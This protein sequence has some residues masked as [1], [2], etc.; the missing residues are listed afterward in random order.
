MRRLVAWGAACPDRKKPEL[1]RQAA[2]AYYEFR[3]PHS[4]YLPR[5][6]AFGMH[7]SLKKQ[8]R[9]KHRIMISMDY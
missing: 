5:K 7:L 1:H 9:S 8:I 6:D 4:D 2:F 3:M